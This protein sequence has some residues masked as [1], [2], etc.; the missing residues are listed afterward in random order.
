MGEQYSPFTVDPHVWAMKRGE[1]E[2]RAMSGWLRFTSVSELP[3]QQGAFQL[4]VVAH[5]YNHSPWKAEARRL[6]CSM[7]AAS[8]AEAGKAQGCLLLTL[9][10]HCPELGQQRH[11]GEEGKAAEESSGLSLGPSLPEVRQRSTFYLHR[12]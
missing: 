9:P 2:V 5:T 10:P 4:G 8:T 11:T 3:S 1:V 6:P 12:T 7:P